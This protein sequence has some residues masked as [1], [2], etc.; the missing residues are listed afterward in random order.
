MI[1]WG[2]PD[3][4]GDSKAVENELHDIVKIYSNDFAFA[5]LRKDGKVITWGAS[6]V[7]GDSSKVADKLNNIKTIIPSYTR[8]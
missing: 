7:G 3:W 6:D 2:D 5:A 4:G 1:T 8:Y